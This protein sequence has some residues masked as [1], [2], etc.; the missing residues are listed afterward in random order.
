MAVS[1]APLTTA[2]MNSV[3]EGE[4]GIASGV[5]N[6]VSRTAGLLA[7]ALLGILFAAVFNGDLEHRVSRLDLQPAAREQ[8]LAQRAK[9]AQIQPPS[10]LPDR[11]AS[12]VRRDVA[13]SFVAAFHGVA[14]AGAVLSLLGALCAW[15]WVGREKPH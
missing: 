8:V 1:I 7:L 2:V 5:N 9:L 6:A 15:V 4:A 3:S 12:A 11:Q 13:H 14:R 10:G